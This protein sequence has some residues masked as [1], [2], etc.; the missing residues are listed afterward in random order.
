MRELE[1]WLTIPCAVPEIGSATL[2]K[3]KARG[4]RTAVL[5]DGDTP[6]PD[7]ADLVHREETYRGYGWAI[8]KLVELIPQAD[9][10]I[11]GGHDNDPDPDRAPQTIGA[12]CVEKFGGLFFVMQPIGDPWMDHCVKSFC[13]SPWIGRDFAKRANRGRGPYWEEYVHY[14][15]DTELQNI[16]IREKC[17]WQRPDLSQEHHHWTKLDPKIRP[18]HLQKHAARVASSRDLFTR[19]RAAGF[20]GSDFLPA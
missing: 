16:A 17:F 9:I 8:N 4:Y 18:E 15:D 6:A 5:V 10:Y 19:R 11:G 12:E 7:N 3:W 14:Y 20:P 2:A 13:G 1:I